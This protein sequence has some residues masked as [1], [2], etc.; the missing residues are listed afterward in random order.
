MKFFVYGKVD[1]FGIL[2]Y[3]TRRAHKLMVL[4]TGYARTRPRVCKDE[5]IDRHLL[6]ASDS[7]ILKCLQFNIQDENFQIVS[8]T[9]YCFETAEE[10]RSPQRRWQ[11]PVRVHYRM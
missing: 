1:E 2:H 3:F 4:F 5:R 9:F 8:T 7:R 11:R 6:H 10:K